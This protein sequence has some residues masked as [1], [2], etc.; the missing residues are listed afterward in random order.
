MYE[1]DKLWDRS[2]NSSFTT[3][4]TSDVTSFHRCNVCSRILATKFEST[5][6]KITFQSFR[7]EVFEMSTLFRH[8]NFWFYY[9]TTLYCI[10][11][12]ILEQLH[13]I[14][15]A[16]MLAMQFPVFHKWPDPDAA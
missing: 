12:E 13:C 2:R 5:S 3:T 8:K 14:S 16:I 15:C 7:E 11:F 4:T 10:E 9:T 1:S 6:R